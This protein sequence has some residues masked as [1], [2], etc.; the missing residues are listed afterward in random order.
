MQLIGACSEMET[1]FF[2]LVMCGDL[3]LHQSLQQAIDIIF[4]GRRIYKKVVHTIEPCVFVLVLLMKLV[5]MEC[6]KKYH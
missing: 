4:E 1:G 6:I 2:L 5:F 3:E